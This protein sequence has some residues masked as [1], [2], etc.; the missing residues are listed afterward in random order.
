MFYS[1]KE[2]A[3]LVWLID[4]LN[5]YH[6]KILDQLNIQH[7]FQPYRSK[8]VFPKETQPTEDSTSVHDLL[9]RWPIQVLV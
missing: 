1:R 4:I 5:Q 3:W 7:S 6:V 2:L 9:R 8:L